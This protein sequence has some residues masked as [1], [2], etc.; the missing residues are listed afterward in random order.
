MRFRVRPQISLRDCA[1]R[2]EGVKPCVSSSQEH[3]IGVCLCRTLLKPRRRHPFYQ[4]SHLRGVV[5][6]RGQR[7]D[8]VPASGRARSDSRLLLF[9]GCFAFLPFQNRFCKFQ[10][11]VP[12]SADVRKANIWGLKGGVA[13]PGAGGRPILGGG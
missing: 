7:G 11:S 6:T 12:L 13:G 4:E 2:R 3:Q 1:Q 9:T 8:L 5:R 10:D